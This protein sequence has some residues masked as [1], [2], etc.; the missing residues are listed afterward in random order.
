MAVIKL[1]NLVLRGS[2]VLMGGTA[3]NPRL[4]TSGAVNPETPEVR[5]SMRRPS[6]DW[7]QEFQPAQ[8][9]RHADYL[10]VDALAAYGAGRSLSRSGVLRRSCLRPTTG[11]A[12]TL[13]S[14]R[15]T[16]AVISVV[17]RCSAGLVWCKPAKRTER[18]SS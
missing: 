4:G 18:A 15:V 2:T 9:L 7:E 11:T 10:R 6:L 14:A 1:E 17:K 3:G 13:V 16:P 12:A 8:R 5:I